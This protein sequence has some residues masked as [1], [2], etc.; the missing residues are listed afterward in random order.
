[1][2]RFCAVEID[3]SFYQ[4]PPADVLEKMAKRARRDFRF[5]VKAH[6]S[7]THGFDLSSAEFG[8]FRRSIAPLVNAGKLGAVLAQ[9]PPA[10]QC[11]RD[12]VQMLRAIREEFYDLPLAVEFRHASWERPE[13]VE[14]LRK[15]A[16][17]YCAADAPSPDSA[18]QPLIVCTANFAYVRL[19]GRSPRWH[20][21]RTVAERHNYLYSEEE[22]ETWAARIETLAENAC[23]V[24]V[25]FSNIY[26]AKAVANARQIARLLDLPS[27]GVPNRRLHRM[28]PELALA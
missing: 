24:Y 15:H 25:M 26:E 14:F 9:F 23:A 12:S 16:I 10:F 13:T 3:S 11:T 27:V 5:T 2:D 8:A 20:D 17:A 4:I 18:A 6:K 28:Q 7:I 19:H 21:A 1:M 22:L